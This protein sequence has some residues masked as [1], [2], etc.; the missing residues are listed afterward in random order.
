MAKYLLIEKHHHQSSTCAAEFSL[1]NA[2][3]WGAITII[4]FI[5]PGKT[6]HS[7]PKNGP[8]EIFLITHDISY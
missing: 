5:K 1:V 8:P 7:Y 3:F 6:I 4:Y 2:P